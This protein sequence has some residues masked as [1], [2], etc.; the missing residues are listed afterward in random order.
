MRNLLW[1]IGMGSRPPY[2]V[3]YAQKACSEYFTPH[4]GRRY[5]LTHR[6]RGIASWFIGL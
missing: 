2:L 1:G 4:S 5:N 3:G 6:H